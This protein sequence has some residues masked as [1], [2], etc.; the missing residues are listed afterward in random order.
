MEMTVNIAPKRTI[1]EENGIVME[2]TEVPFIPI[3][4]Q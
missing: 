2:H 3:D 1:H 4:A